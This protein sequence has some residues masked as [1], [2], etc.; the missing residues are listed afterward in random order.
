CGTSLYMSRTYAAMREA[1][2]H[3]ETDAFAASEFPTARRYDRVIGLSRSGTTT[4]LIEAVSG[5]VAHT[6]TTVFTVDPTSPVA[7]PGVEVIALDFAAEESVVQTRFP[8]AV[9]AMLRANLGQ[10]LTGVIAQGEAAVAD[11]LPVD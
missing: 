3:G 2:G 10:D 9:L 5:T 1:A 6:P 7:L 4:E 11:P 8:T